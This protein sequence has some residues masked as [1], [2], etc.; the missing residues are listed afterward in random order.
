M[1]EHYV[2]TIDLMMDYI[3]KAQKLL[4]NDAYSTKYSDVVLKSLRQLYGDLGFFHIVGGLIKNTNG[5]K[6]SELYRFLS[7]GKGFEHNVIAYLTHV[8]RGYLTGVFFLIEGILTLSLDKDPTSFISYN[9]LVQEFAKRTDLDE[10]DVKILKCGSSIRNSFHNG[11][12][13]IHDDFEV[14]IEGKKFQ[15]KKN[16]EV[17]TSITDIPIVIFGGVCVLLK[18]LQKLQID[19]K[20]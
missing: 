20:R 19:S 16:K 13:H 12:I 10:Q 5:N 15:F 17:D 7:Y 18:G 2:V 1:S 9:K 11:G 6:S 8:E 3:D 4:K 14:S